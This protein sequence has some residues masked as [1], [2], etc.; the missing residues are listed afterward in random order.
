[1]PR[2]YGEMAMIRPMTRA[3]TVCLLLCLASQTCAQETKAKTPDVLAELGEAFDASL[4][5]TTSFSFMVAKHKAGTYTLVVEK[6]PEG[7]DAVYAARVDGSVQAGAER[8]VGHEEFLL[9]GTFSLL[10]RVAKETQADGQDQTLD[11]ARV[12]GGWTYL[13]VKPT[14]R[15]RKL[16]TFEGKNHWD[17]IS[18]LLLARRLKGHAPV[19]FL[20]HGVEWSGDQGKGVVM[21]AELSALEDFEHRGETVKAR[22]LMVVRP[23]KDIMILQVDTGG[24]LLAW[25]PKG[26][27]I[28]LVAGTAKQLEADDAT[29][30]Q[31]EAGPKTALGAVVV[32]FQVMGKLKPAA[33]LDA[34]LDWKAIHAEMVAESPNVGILSIEALADLMKRQIGQAP[35]TMSKEQ[36]DM[37]TSMLQV[38]IDGDKATVE[39]PGGEGDDFFKLVKRAEGWKIVH[40][41]H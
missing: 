36:L 39:A 27:P 41:P 24:R 18:L 31:L 8:F 26:A 35:A 10:S 2:P 9:D 17:P 40:F 14:K 23:G 32:Y 12:P 37:L 38:K 13:E 22:R 30:K 3:L 6:A 34:V 16:S 29:A 4:C 11:I 20:L 5:G 15:T 19:S 7:S 28:R 25:W 33:A 1:M 21:P